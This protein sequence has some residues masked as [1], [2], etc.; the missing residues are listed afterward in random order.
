MGG[1]QSGVT[2]DG[3]SREGCVSRAASEH[4]QLASEIAVELQSHP[5]LTSNCNAL[6]QITDTASHPL[7][8]PVAVDVMPVPSEPES[9]V[10]RNLQTYLDTF[11]FV[12]T[13]ALFPD[14]GRTPHALSMGW[15]TKNGNFFRNANEVQIFAVD[16]K[17]AT[18][19]AV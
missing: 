3:A 8:P 14:A 16:L 18:I 1:G 17:G 7:P 5:E 19:S 6:G 4:A 9:L 11:E 10:L 2:R 12:P 15:G 13:F